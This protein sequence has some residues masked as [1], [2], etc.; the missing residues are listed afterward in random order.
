[1]ESLVPFE[2]DIYIDM[3]NDKI[4][5]QKEESLQAELQREAMKSK[6]MI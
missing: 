5:K 6:G 1:M 4:E 2:R 3:I